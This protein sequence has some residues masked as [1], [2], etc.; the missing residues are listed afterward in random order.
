ML[1]LMLN[2][3]LILSIIYLQGIVVLLPILAIMLMILFQT[4][5]L[6]SIKP[7]ED[8]RTAVLTIFN[9][10]MLLFFAYLLVLFTDFVETKITNDAGSLFIVGTLF[11]IVVNLTFYFVPLC[12]HCKRSWKRR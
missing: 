4:G 8:P 7:Y 2:L 1:K 9:Y 12:H 10:I 11:S 6:L 3:I 5:W